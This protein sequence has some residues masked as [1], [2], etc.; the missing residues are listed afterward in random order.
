MTTPQTMTSSGNLPKEGPG[1]AKYTVEQTRVRCETL[2]DFFDETTGKR[3]KRMPFWH[4]HNGTM[5]F[6]FI[7]D[8]ITKKELLQYIRQGQVYIL[9]QHVRTQE[10]KANLKSE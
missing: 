2:K 1:P 8:T 7:D 4:L 10:T 5:V 9:P 6:D 3:I